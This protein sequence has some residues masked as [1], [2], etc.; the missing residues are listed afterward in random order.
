MNKLRPDRAKH[1]PDHGHGLGTLADWIEGKKK[2]A[3]VAAATA[4]EAPAAP[5]AP[6]TP[7]V[8]PD[9]KLSLLGVKSQQ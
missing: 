3:A 5:P 7:A 1:R 8:E 9:G 2:P 6:D 4:P